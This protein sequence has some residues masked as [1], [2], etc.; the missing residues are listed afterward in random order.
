MKSLACKDLG[1]PECD[2]VATAETAEEVVKAMTEH[3]VAMHK[4]KVDEMAK[5]MTPEQM[6]AMMMA[7]VGDVA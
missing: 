2:F 4:D 3:A 7:K 1:A 6:N 5:T